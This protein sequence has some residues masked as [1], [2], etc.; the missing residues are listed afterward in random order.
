MHLHK[1]TNPIELNGHQ[2]SVWKKLWFAQE[3]G[4]KLQRGELYK[5]WS[6]DEL[7]TLQAHVKR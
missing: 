1:Q 5:A 4:D 2:V 6:F 7:N 3:C